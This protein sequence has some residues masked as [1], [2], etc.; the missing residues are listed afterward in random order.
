VSEKQVMSDGVERAFRAHYGDVYRFVRRRVDSRAEAEDVVA[1]VFLAAASAL[2]CLERRDTPALAWLYTVARR[3]LVDEARR[4]GRSPLAEARPPVEYGP[5]LAAAIGRALA[6]LPSDQR[7]LVVAKLVQGRSFRSLAQE[8]GISE[9]ACK[10][11]V[12][13]ALERVREALAQEGVEP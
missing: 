7:T 9:A 13:R 11:R 8:R 6:A 5:S 3:R 1:D 4:R 10:M 2:P 12:A